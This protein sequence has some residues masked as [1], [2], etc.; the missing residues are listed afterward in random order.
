MW[1]GGFRTCKTDAF[2]AVPIGHQV[3]ED[4]SLEAWVAL[5]PPSN[6]Y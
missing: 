6:N 2:L 4:F 1:F 3:L 5:A